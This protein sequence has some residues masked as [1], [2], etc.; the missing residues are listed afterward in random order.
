VHAVTLDGVI[1][2]LGAISALLV[3]VATLV[4]AISTHGKVGGLTAKINGHLEDLLN[5][6]LTAAYKGMAP[7]NVGPPKPAGD[8]NTSTQPA[9]PKPPAVSP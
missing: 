3:A 4:T 6:A 9:A 1:A 7:P 8:F 2:L 5:A